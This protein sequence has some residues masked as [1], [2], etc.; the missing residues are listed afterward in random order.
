[1]TTPRK[2][3]P[4]PPSPAQ[5]PEP[6][7]ER[8]ACPTCGRHIDLLLDGTINWHWPPRGSEPCPAS[9]HPYTADHGAH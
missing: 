7:P 3:L 5:Q 1:M 2:P 6:A 4:P 9:T 8:P